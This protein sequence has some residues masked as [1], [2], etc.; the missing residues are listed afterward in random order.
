[1]VVLSAGIAMVVV[2]TRT[3]AHMCAGRGGGG[4]NWVRLSVCSSARFPDRFTVGIRSVSSGLE[5]SST[6]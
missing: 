6:V 4:G 2:V 1:M 3:Y 5:K